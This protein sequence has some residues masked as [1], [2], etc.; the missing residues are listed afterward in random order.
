MSRDFGTFRSAASF[1]PVDAL[2]GKK[3]VF[4]LFMNLCL[5]IKCMFK[6]KKRS[7]TVG[8]RLQNKN[9]VRVEYTSGVMSLLDAAQHP[10]PPSFC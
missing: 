7:V 6:V 4:K 1:R 2:N 9:I 5:L 3:G 10:S 8:G